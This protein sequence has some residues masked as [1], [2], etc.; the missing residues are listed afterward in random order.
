[1]VVDYSNGKIYAIKNPNTHDVYVG[2]TCQKYI[3]MRFEAHRSDFKAWKRG[4]KK[5]CSS[6]PLFFCE[7]A[8]VE[9]L[10]TFPCQNIYEL[11]KRE[12]HWIEKIKCV[13]KSVPSRKHD[14]YRKT[15]QC[16][17]SRQKSEQ[18]RRRNPKRLE[19]QRKYRIKYYQEN[20]DKWKDE[21]GKFK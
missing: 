3:S 8:C 11:R 15:E 19:Y 6:F 13:N 1:M 5:W 10:E 14:E 7:G 2:S 18:K 20:K 4:A 16:R 12:R 17:V 9:I 21:N